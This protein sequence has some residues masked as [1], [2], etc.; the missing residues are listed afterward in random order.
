MR[1]FPAFTKPEVQASKAGASNRVAVAAL[2]G[3]VMAERTDAET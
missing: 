3:Q 2:A 1:H